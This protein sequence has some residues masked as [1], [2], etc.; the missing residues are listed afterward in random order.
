MTTYTIFGAGPGGLYT[1]WRLLSSDRLEAN[2]TL[3][4]IEWGDYSFGAHKGTRRP[5]GRIASYNYDPENL[6]SSYLEVGGMRYLPWGPT[7]KSTKYSPISGGPDGHKLVT[8]TI[9]AL[10]MTDEVIPFKTTNDPLFY[11]RGFHFYQDDLNKPL[12]EARSA[13][14]AVQVDEKGFYSGPFTNDQGV[15][16]APYHTP[17]NTGAPSALFTDT[18]EG[19][20]SGNK[21]DTRAKQCAFYSKGTLPSN[22]ENPI[23]APETTVSNIG[24][25]N[26]FYSMAGNE[27][28]Q[29]AADAGG[30]SS[31]VINWNTANAVV[32]NGEFAPDG[33]FATLK[34]GYSSLFEELYDKIVDLAAQ[35]GVNFDL[36][37]KTRLHS[38]WNDVSG[39]VP[40]PC[41]HLATADNPDAPI[42]GEP[43]SA[44]YIFLAMPPESLKLV[45]QATQYL[46][47]DP[48]RHY[49]MNDGA[50]QT[51]MES[52]ILQPSY[53]VGMFFDSPWWQDAPYAPQLGDSSSNT[54][55]P[56]V[57]DLP[58]RQMYYFGDNALSSSQDEPKVYGMLAS[59]DDMRFTSFWNIMETPVTERI[60]TPPSTKTQ[61]LNGAEEAP[62]SMVD[63]LLLQLSKVHFGTTEKVDA[64]P[65][66]LKTVYMDWG[67]LPFGAGYHAWQA[68]FDIGAVMQDIRAPEL[69]QQ[70]VDGQN[71]DPDAARTFIIGSAYSNDQAWVEGAF[72][73][74]ESV[75]QDYF[76]IHDGFVVDDDGAY[77]LI[78]GGRHCG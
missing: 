15:V 4:M 20:M 72:C 55:G 9:K 56:T 44:D 33:S 58:L 77:P 78:C 42:A 41:Y 32:Y 70:K 61:P 62:Q 64:I 45:S 40:K 22:F 14:N 35:K 11:L 52:V 71:F 76:Y 26:I 25:W 43:E 24:Y 30:Y 21:L 65:K 6:K 8:L 47:K 3:K 39:S 34:T 19:I 17:A 13:G 54:F 5:A 7:D 31:N 60:T 73:T 16:V 18:S 50:V 28:F 46:P 38:I 10:A 57:T 12:K 37:Q 51:A 27:G 2:D 63:M 75:L 29:Y 68:H 48:K 53:K 23:F 69:L 59:Y 74:A 66:P 49:F 67:Q 1:A 36:Q